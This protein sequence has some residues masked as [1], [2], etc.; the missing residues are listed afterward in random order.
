VHP[1]ANRHQNK[2]PTIM[3]ASAN[4]VLNPDKTKCVVEITD[5]LG[6]VTQFE[7]IYDV[8]GEG[9]EVILQT[10]DGDYYILADYGD[11]LMLYEPDAIATQHTEYE[12]DLAD[13][14]K[15]EEGDETGDA[16]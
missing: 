11:G 5:G 13:Y 12:G 14:L 3:A 2:E 16:A 10:E 6:E 4:I 7:D 15:E 9:D 1:Q 8:P